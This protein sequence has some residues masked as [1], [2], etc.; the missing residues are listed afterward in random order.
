[1]HY[2]GAPF[3]IKDGLGDG[4]LSSFIGCLFA[5]FC[6]VNS[7]TVGNIIQINASASAAYDTFGLNPLTVG[8]ITAGVTLAVIIGGAQRISTLTS[9]LIPAVSMIYIF[10]CVS[11]IIAYR[12]FFLDVI[13]EIFRSAFSFSAAVGGVGGYTVA[14]AVRFGVTRGILTNE[15]GSGTSPTAHAS[16][17]A[18]TPHEQGLLGIFEVF[19]DTIIICSLTAF[20]VLCAGMAG[21][22]MSADP[23]LTASLTFSSV[24]GCTAPP[25]LVFVSDMFVLATIISQHYYGEVAISYLTEKKTV[26]MAYTVIFLLTTVCGSV[27]SPAIIWNAADITVGAMT[28]VNVICVFLMRRQVMEEFS[29]RE[30]VTRPH[31][32]RKSAAF[33]E[34]SSCNGKKSVLKDR[35][36]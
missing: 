1:N 23:M 33:G 2:G 15:A 14:E 32:I 9:R 29:S 26:K 12:G 24:L 31:E 25:I 10:M 16:S 19:A 6:I 5:I 35:N 20:A 22:T 17:D 34:K 18:K 21:L 11:V 7:L 27:M 30:I 28:S 36:I 8:I 13:D 4:K 3:Y